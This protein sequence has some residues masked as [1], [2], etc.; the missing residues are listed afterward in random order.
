MNGQDSDDDKDR[1]SFLARWA[2]RKAE[3]GSE[4][5]AAEQ[6]AAPEFQKEAPIA[7]EPFDLASLPSLESL[8]AETDVRPF[9]NALVPEGLRNA[10][11]RRVWELDT[12]IRDYV[13]PATEYAWNWNET[14][15]AQG[16][17]PLEAGDKA[18]QYVEKL[19]S[20]GPAHHPLGESVQE[21][22]A[23][24]APAV[25]SQE[26]RAKQEAQNIS[27]KTGSYNITQK[28]LQNVG[29]STKVDT[30]PNLCGSAPVEP[31]GEPANPIPQTTFAALQKSTSRHGGATPR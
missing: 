31:S 8:T 28:I 14:G 20:S 22:A 4:G 7:S 2:R 30:N 3:A 15:G 26:A 27:M 25:A 23:V 5:L 1:S 21:P 11:L 9:M 13:S 19:F 17:G 24:D 6:K 16:F 18:L 29:I 12:A 10:A